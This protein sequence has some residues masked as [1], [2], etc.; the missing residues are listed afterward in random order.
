MDVFAIVQGGFLIQLVQ[1]HH[2]VMLMF[3]AV[4]MGLRWIWIPQMAASASAQT[5][6]PMTH[7]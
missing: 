4:A 7:V 1:L 5:A 6:S 3:T 2:P